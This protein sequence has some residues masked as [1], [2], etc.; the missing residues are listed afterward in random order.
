M[1]KPK[2]DIKPADLAIYGGIA[3]GLFTI[4]RKLGL[5]KKSEEKKTKEE[6]TK[7]VKGDI[8]KEERKGNYPSFS[9]TQYR[10]FAATIWQGLN[11]SVFVCRDGTDEEKIYKVLRSLKNNTDWLKLQEA[12][13]FKRIEFTLQDGGLIQHL[14][15]DMSSKQLKEVNK[16]LS[17]R[18][19]TYKV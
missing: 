4:G 15:A 14:N 16:I 8:I 18:G 10:N 9:K 19:I 11:C 17:E 1:K 2:I 7:E 3:I 5:F 6:T 12:F 13:G